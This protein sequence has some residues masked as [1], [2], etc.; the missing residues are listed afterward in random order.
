[1]NLPGIVDVVPDAVEASDYG[2]L[3]GEEGVSHP[4]CKYRIF[5]AYCLA[6]CDAVV[7]VTGNVAVTVT[8]FVACPELENAAEQG[9]GSYPHKQKQRQAA[10]DYSLDCHSN[11]QC[12]GD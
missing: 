11:G 6:G 1:M 2:C 12:K 5:L 4:D 3:R 10:M 8:D 9:N 7:A